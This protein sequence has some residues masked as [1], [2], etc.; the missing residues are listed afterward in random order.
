MM[1]L[2]VCGNQAPWLPPL[3]RTWG[4]GVPGNS[5]KLEVHAVWKQQAG[6]C[7]PA[8]SLAGCVTFILL[9]NLSE[10]QSP[11]GFKGSDTSPPRIFLLSSPPPPPQKVVRRTKSNVCESTV[12]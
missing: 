12:G 6:I 7:V 10:P 8:L 2:G 4:W 5:G 1:D 3:L 9:L 11:N